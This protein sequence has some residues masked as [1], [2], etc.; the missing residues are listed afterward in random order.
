MLNHDDWITEVLWYRELRS[1]LQNTWNERPAL[2]EARGW[3][4]ENFH[5]RLIEL[6]TS[7]ISY[8]KRFLPLQSSSYL[9]LK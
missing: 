1:T 8:A 3:A 5:K 2:P 9:A 6:D 7:N 4:V